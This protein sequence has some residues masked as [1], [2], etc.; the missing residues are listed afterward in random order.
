MTITLADAL[1]LVREIAD[2]PEPGVLFQD[3]NPALADPTAFRVLVD[4][5]AAGVAPGTDAV[6]AIEARGF[7]L[8]AALGYA[9]GVGVVCVRKPG[10][11]PVVDHRVEYGLEYGA[12]TLELPR[13]VVRPGRRLVI[14]DDVLATGGT[15]AAARHLVESAGGVV[16]GVSVLLEITALGGR[17]RLGGLAVTA[18]ASV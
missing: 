1:G 11:L 12:A 13:G 3:I 16:T 7:L 6:V 5:L 18:L 10:K 17:D 2:F 15:A 8:G 4:A 9:L 14:V